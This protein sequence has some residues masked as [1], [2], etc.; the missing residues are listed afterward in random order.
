MEPPRILRKMKT[1]FE[2]P[3][4]YHL[5]IGETEI[6]LNDF[7]GKP[8]KLN[9]LGRIFCIQCARKISKTFQQGFC[10]PC[11][12]RLLECNLCILHPERCLVETGS[13]STIDW[14]HLQC[15]QTH[16][17]YLANASGVKV[18]ITRMSH[19]PTRWL[20]Q[21]AIQALPI[22]KV[23]NRYRAGLVEVALKKFVSDRT[24]WRV[25]LKNEVKAMDLLSFRDALFQKTEEVLNKIREEFKGDVEFLQENPVGITY[26]VLEY[27]NKINA[28]S[29]D[30]TSALGGILLGIKGQYLIFDS[31]VI[32]LRKFGGY[33][34]E[35]I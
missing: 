20:D 33:E 8:L 2:H 25:M 30:K 6:L 26:P 23:Q 17:V 27:P 3:I 24:N 13:C 12:Q 34:V 14:A 32:N 19:L 18:G 28:L 4:R 1:T 9:F 21:G 16:V 11:Y 35:V 22:I 5:R 29:F 31:G 7:L 15:H 10:Y